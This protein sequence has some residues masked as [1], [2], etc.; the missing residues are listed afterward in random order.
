MTQN[1]Q[2]KTAISAIVLILVTLFF[3]KVFDL[4]YPLSI[5]TTNRS[6]EL[7]V[8]GEGKVDAVPDIAY[9]DAG[10]SVAN[11]ATVEEAQSTINKIN[12]QIVKAA[13]A[14]GI[15]KE[16]ITTSNYSVNPNYTYPN[17]VQQLSGYSGNVTVSLKVRDT[18]NVSQILAAVTKAGA[19][20]I[21]N[22]QFSIDNPDKLREEARNKAIQNA[23][24][25]AARLAKTLGIRLGKIVNIS[26]SNSSSTQPPFY[27]GGVGGMG[28]G[29]ADSAPVEPGSQTV[30]STVT[31]FFER[32]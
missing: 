14:L 30:N 4:S 27:K 13:Q 25:Q 9:I 6:S 31:L 29:V 20:Q 8:V 7:S 10:I 24:D 5:V 1:A 16:D 23:K 11:A 17:D 22:V 32:K 15:K 2:L 12:G 28:A 3:I 19:N 18:K 21:Q 26:E